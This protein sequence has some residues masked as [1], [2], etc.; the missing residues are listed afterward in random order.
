MNLKR[1]LKKYFPGLFST[2]THLAY[3][4]EESPNKYP[5][6]KVRYVMIAEYLHQ[7]YLKRGK[8][9]R[10]L[11]IGCSE[12]MMIAYTQKNNTQTEFYG[13]DILE[14]RKAKAIARGYKDVWLKDIRQCDFSEYRDRFD[15][16]I[17]SHILEHLEHPGDL[18]KKL[19]SVMAEDALLVVGTPIGLWPGVL[20]SRYGAPLRHPWYRREAVLKRFGHVSFFTLSS[21][22]KLLLKNRFRTEECRG[23]YFIRARGFFLE[24]YKWWFDF[25]QWYG[26]LF[27][28]VLG[29][30]VV[31]ARRMEPS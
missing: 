30:V 9:L 10:I 18:L 24:D 13:I 26:R 28:G 3:G 16:V 4:V 25:N 14:E 17:C 22:K 21:L 12:G 23:E 2:K 7:E 19:N 27:P 8:P 29:Y 6:D 20:W 31:R 11:D 1:S 5:L 15:A